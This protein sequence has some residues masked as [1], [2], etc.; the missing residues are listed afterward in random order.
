MDDEYD[1]IVKNGDSSFKKEKY[2]DAI[3]EYTKAYAM[4]DGEAK[5]EICYKLSQAYFSLEPKNTDNP[6]KYANEA[7]D[8]HKKLEE[9]DMAVMDIINLGYIFLNSGKRDEA[10]KYFDQA[11]SISK[12]IKDVQ[13]IA[14][15]NNA[16]AE[17]LSTLKS[18][19]NDALAIYNDVINIT[20]KSHDWEN[21]FEAVYGEINILRTR[22]INEA[23]ELGKKN[24][25]LIDTIIAGIKT[26]KDKKEFR[27]S[28]AYMYDVTSDMAME[29]ENIDE[30]M[31]I[32]ARLAN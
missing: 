28:L 12:E 25:D 26:K 17:A 2:M 14:L 1:D 8:I 9:Q 6:I 18:K 21:Y 30:A 27:D 20:E 10:I 22:D 13:L 19:H 4:A 16:K 7:L 11:I 5:A 29:L 15:T 32:A 24:L 23:F 3:R 31:K